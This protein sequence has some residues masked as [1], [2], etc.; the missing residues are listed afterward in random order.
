M[1]RTCQ[2]KQER[3]TDFVTKPLDLSKS[4]LIGRALLYDSPYDVSRSSYGA[5]SAVVYAEDSR[6][7]ITLCRNIAANLI[8]VFGY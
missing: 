4:A 5:V 1:S 2:D 3:V 7:A 8:S 6:N